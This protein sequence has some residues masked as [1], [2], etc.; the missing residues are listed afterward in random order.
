MYEDISYVDCIKKQYPTIEDKDYFVVDRGNG[1]EITFWDDQKLGPK[2]TKEQLETA[3]VD[4]VKDMHI[5]LVK[6]WFSESFEKGFT[7]PSSGIKMDCRREDLYNLTNLRDYMTTNNQTNVTIRDLN[8]NFHNITME[9]LNFLI[10]SL[11]GYGLWL[12]QHKWELEEIIKSKTSIN[13]IEQII[14]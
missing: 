8:N 11:I 9:Q 13:E 4:V 5:S 1:F 2:P 7:C 6:D 10:T 14:W 12:Y 3:W